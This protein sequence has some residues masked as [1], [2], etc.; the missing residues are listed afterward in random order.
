VSVHHL[1][2]EGWVVVPLER[3]G[4]P[5]TCHHTHGPCERECRSERTN[6]EI[7][8]E[9]EHAEQWLRACLE[10]SHAAIKRLRTGP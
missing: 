8:E 1:G 6:E 2:T 10:A 4:R 9:L 7:V 5:Y 3:E